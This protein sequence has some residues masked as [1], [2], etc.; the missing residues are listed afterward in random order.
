MNQ[1]VGIDVQANV[2]GVQQAMDTTAAGVDNIG[3]AAGRASQ[4]IKDLE[5][6]VQALLKRLEQLGQTGGRGFGVP[7][8]PGIP[9]GP[10]CLPVVPGAPPSSAPAGSPAL[11]PR[12]LPSAPVPARTPHERALSSHGYNF[13]RF[14]H[15]G[16]HQGLQGLGQMAGTPGAA[17]VLSG[18]LRFG[19]AGA[20]MAGIGAT[21]AGLVQS[22]GIATNEA[23]TIDSL[24][25][26]LGDVGVNFNTLRDMN[27]SASAG[28][29][30]SS[31]E[32]ASY[33]RQFSRSANLRGQGGLHDELR[34]AYG[35]SRA[36]GMDPSAGVGFF[37]AMRG[38]KVTIDETSSKKLGAILAESLEK[39]GNVAQA[40][41]VMA[42]IQQFA[43][44]AARST[45]TMPNIEAF[46]GGVS[47]LTRMR[48][49]GLDAQGAGS[50]L[51]Q[52]DQAMRQGGAKG[53]ASLNVGYAALSQ[54]NPGISAFGAKALMGLGLFGTGKDLEGSPW[55][56]MTGYKSTG[57]TT[58][59]EAVRGLIKRF[60][61]GSKE[62][63]ASSMGGMFGLNEQQ[64]AVMAQFTPDQM[65]GIE[66]L[67]KRRGIDFGKINSGGMQSLASIA[68]ARNM[69]DL[70]PVIRSVRDRKDISGADKSALKAALDTGE[71]GKVQD[72]LTDILSRTDQE[73][74]DGKKSLEVQKQMETALARIGENLI[75]AT[76][77]I[78]DYAG[79][80]VTVFAGG[81]EESNAYLAE[82][83]RMK[84]TAD[85]EDAVHKQLERGEISP[86]TADKMLGRETGWKGAGVDDA[87]L[88]AIRKIESG[89][90]RFAVSK[91][92][93]RGPFQFMPET[94]KRFG[95]TDP[96][97]EAQSRRGAREY[98][99]LLKKRYR[100]DER[101]ALTAY[102]WGEGNM[103]AYLKNGR[104]KYGQAMPRETR[105]YADKVLAARDGNGRRVDELDPGA[106][107]RRAESGKPA[108]VNVHNTLDI[109]LRDPQQR[110]V[111]PV[112]VV[113]NRIPVP[114]GG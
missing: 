16:L 12:V 22:H 112:A 46:A 18:G 44:S 77:M 40:Q 105:E 26:Q 68:G 113:G 39:G 14:A 84:D 93:A 7:G 101:N 28:Y 64:A 59:F 108:A 110:P 34:N 66:Q 65:G 31:V 71:F 29:G 56:K 37:G 49:P 91:A 92:G 23:H 100:G 104:G 45:L 98:M 36:Y 51:M 24:K 21:I 6:N 9:G 1:R 32:S 74:T 72:V 85:M 63:F 19:L 13:G 73:M 25:R 109:T 76:N 2:Q 62:V 79:R 102:N 55:G 15:S 42:A 86:S 106:A 58:N 4:R 41:E 107:G 95:I 17:S 5:K 70:V 48:L 8:I 57:D 111:A 103:D 67:V 50:M 99:A 33:A 47:A 81:S 52:A 114:V 89:G 27:R 53:E 61:G 94:A 60:Y 96:F 75:P 43:S 38:I 78:R 35:I 88:D 83:K 3:K 20:G 69:G 82:R 54:A 80:L 90:N 87:T 11:P 97:D 30:I 10:G